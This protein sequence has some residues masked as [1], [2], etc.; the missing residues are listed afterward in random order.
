MKKFKWS[1]QK[2][3]DI[4]TQQQKVIQNHLYVISQKLIQQQMLLAAK[5]KELKEM[6]M[7][8]SRK[9]PAERIKAQQ[10][11]MKYSNQTDK[12]IRNIKKYIN[13]I[14]I[15][16]NNKQ[17][18]LVS[19]KKET[20][21]LEKLRDKEKKLFIYN[22]EKLEQNELDETA[23]IAFTRKTLVKTNNIK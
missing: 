20:E 12:I 6:L 8:I 16:K 18:E 19:S 23:T 13:D 5:K 17:A 15:Q 3:L 14:K 9:A 7:D 4:K 11:F 2:V 21:T 10:L 1:L 22:Q